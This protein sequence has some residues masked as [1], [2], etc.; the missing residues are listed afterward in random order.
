MRAAL[1]T[2]TLGLS[3][4]DLDR[5]NQDDLALEE[6]VPA[7]SRL[8]R[9]LAPPEVLPMLRALLN[10]FRVPARL[11]GADTTMAPASPPLASEA[12]GERVLTDLLHLAELL[13]QAS[14]LLDGEQ[15]LIRYLAEQCQEA[16]AVAATMPGRSAWRATPTWCRW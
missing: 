13:Q 5:L 11:L 10:D 3:W 6:R 1:A 2:R 15:A 4:A 9:P 12:S 7:I 16:G 8:P 14:L